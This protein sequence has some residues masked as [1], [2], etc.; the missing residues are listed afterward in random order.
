MSLKNTAGP[1]I[2][3]EKNFIIDEIEYAY[4]ITQLEKEEGILIS[5]FEVKP[6]K[7]ITFSCQATSE[8][9]TKKI[10]KL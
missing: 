1:P 4:L 2:K 3:G 9:I 10:K 7:N 5:L 8:Q 6:V